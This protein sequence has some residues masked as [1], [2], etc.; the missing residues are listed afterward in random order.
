M[1]LELPEEGSSLGLGSA[2]GGGG[3]K[4]VKQEKELRQANR[5]EQ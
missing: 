3:K 1:K 2:G 4:R 5:V